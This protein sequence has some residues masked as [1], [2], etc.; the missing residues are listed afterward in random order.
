MA[1]DPASKLQAKAEQLKSLAN[2][3]NIS[4][5]TGSAASALRDALPTLPSPVTSAEGVLNVKQPPNNSSLVPMFGDDM[6]NTWL[7]LNVEDIDFFDHNPRRSNNEKYQELKAS[8][9]NSGLHSSF[10][11]TKRPGA[12]RYMVESG[13][14]TRLAILKELSEETGDPKFKKITVVFK[15]Y[16]NESTVIARHLS[17]NLNR[18]SLPFWDTAQSVYFLR[19]TLQNEQG[20]QLSIRQFCESAAQLGS[21]FQSSVVSVMLFC[22]EYLSPIGPYI[23]HASSRVIMPKINTFVRVGKI[24][25]ESPDYDFMKNV[26]VPIVQ[27]YAD[28]H[29]L[30]R[31]ELVDAPTKEEP[32]L[33]VEHFFKFL[34]ESI[35]SILNI[36]GGIAVFN[37]IISI[38]DQYKDF[39]KE[40]ILGMLNPVFPVIPPTVATTPEPNQSAPIV[41][42]ERESQPSVVNAQASNAPTVLTAQE[43]S[44]NQSEQAPSNQSAASDDVVTTTVSR[45]APQPTIPK[46]ETLKTQLIQEIREFLAALD[47]DSLISDKPSMPLGFIINKPDD[48]FTTEPQSNEKSFVW[49]LVAQLTQQMD[50][51]LCLENLPDDDE[52]RF[53]MENNDIDLEINATFGNS[54]NYLPIEWTVTL[55]HT[56][57]FGHLLK[58]L[59]ISRAYHQELGV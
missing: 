18:G 30:N 38:A 52:W 6:D 39:G 33:D 12:S 48:S 41:H 22:V 35:S 50:Y 10:S 47:M 34:G 8:I 29:L 53:F 4:V 56:P 21:E 26:I 16:I 23:N 57:F 5:K 42:S 13:A 44:V 25:I 46:I 31:H 49:G 1:A 15:K 14:N 40:E 11:V 55:I 24:W 27:K 59:T 43:T 54:A 3:K 19:T 37:K 45:A 58:L 20:K 51:A 9:R 36:D 7:E 17:E 32:V 28:Q 2:A